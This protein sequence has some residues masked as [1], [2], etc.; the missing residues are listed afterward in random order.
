M[1]GGPGIPLGLSGVSMVL[2]GVPKVDLGQTP[3]TTLD[4]PGVTAHKPETLR[5]P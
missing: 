2:R 3:F 5:S 4:T 1:K